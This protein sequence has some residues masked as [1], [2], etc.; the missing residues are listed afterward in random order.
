[1]SNCVFFLNMFPD[2]E[3]PEELKE[4]LSQAAIVAADIDLE[5][6]SVAV[7]VH[8]PSYMPRRLLNQVEM[9]LSIS[10]GLR[11]LELTA[12]FPPEQLHKCEPVEIMSL[13]VTANSMNRSSLAG[14]QWCWEEDNLIIKL[15][16]N[17]KKE[18]EEVLPTVRNVLRERFAAP[19]EIII[20]AGQNLEGQALF[21]EIEKMR[22]S[23]MALTRWTFVGT[24]LSLL[25]NML[26]RLAITFLQ[27]VSIF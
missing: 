18:L 11:K 5:H 24:I 22:S 4:A 8:T 20:E 10:Y 2:Y 21:D 7:A 13:F 19:V 15:R 14:A 23:A 12:T 17:G 1:M 25:F 16:G 3:P 27:G 26:S 6:G 9:D